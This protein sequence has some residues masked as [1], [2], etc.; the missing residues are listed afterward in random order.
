M[1]AV[2]FCGRIFLFMTVIII[3]EVY[4]Y[5]MNKD[6][7]AKKNI[8]FYIAFAICIV[9]VAAAAWT[10]YGSVVEYGT[11]HDDISQSEDVRTGNEVSG[12]E[13]STA[14]EDKKEQSDES[15]TE[16]STEISDEESK[17]DEESDTAPVNTFEGQGDPA[18]PIETGEVIKKFSPTVPVYSKTTSD[19]RVHKGVDVSAAEGTAVHSVTDGVVTAVDKSYMYGNMITVEGRD[20]K[21]M[22]YGLSETPVVRIGNEVKAGDTIGYSGIVPCELLDE[23]HI[24]VEVKKGDE[25]IDLESLFNA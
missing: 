10:T 22:Y 14:D 5:I 11:G 15:S 17:A 25:Y 6:N 19:W 13:Y 3:T 9:S 7:S 21:I 16:E 1:Q 12:E 2:S 20:Y 24:H 23:S 4:C 18:F 8:G